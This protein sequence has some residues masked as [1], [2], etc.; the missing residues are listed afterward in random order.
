MK[1][2]KV[3]IGQ[4]FGWYGRCDKQVVIKKVVVIEIESRLDKS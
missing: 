3:N 4:F 1:P 2:V